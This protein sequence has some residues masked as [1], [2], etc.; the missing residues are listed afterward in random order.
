MGNS[1][2]VK[3][4]KSYNGTSLT[5]KALIKATYDVTSM[6]P[7]EYTFRSYYGNDE[8]VFEA[9]GLEIPSSTITRFPFAEYHTDLDTPERLCTEAMVQTYEI[10]KK[11]IEIVENNYTAVS[12]KP[13]LYCLSNPKYD[14]YRS[15]PE[16][17]ISDAGLSSTEKNW[18]LMMNCLPRDLNS[19]M[20]ILDISIKYEIEFT[21]L[22]HYVKEWEKKGL[23]KLQHI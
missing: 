15:A 7:E 16:P 2:P 18:N 6:R 20:S 17:G 1:S 9:P 12:V 5:D 10:L 14:L 13:G 23:I 4:Q 11:T 21:A 22:N 8:T 3:I 19:G